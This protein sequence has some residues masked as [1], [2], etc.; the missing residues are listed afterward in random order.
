MKKILVF[1]DSHGSTANMRKIVKA[2]NPDMIIHLGDYYSD[3]Q[4]LEERFPDIPLE[5]VK[6]NCDSELRPTEKLLEIE[7]KKI[8]ICHGHNYRVK[9]GLLELEYAA[10]EKGADAVFFG[11]THRPFYDFDGRLHMMNPGSIGAPRYPDTY[12]YGL[13]F[14]EKGEIF[15][16]LMPYGN[17]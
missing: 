13:L 2:E 8:F 5:A 12:S 9:S 17:K 1:A 3:A 16:R 4:A 11:H 7:G 15:I 6:G 14:I 10:L